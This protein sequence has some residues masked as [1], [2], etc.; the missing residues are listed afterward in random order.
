MLENGGSVV[1]ISETSA[2]KT[3]GVVGIWTAV[4]SIER[5]FGFFFK[6]SS[7]VIFGEDVIGDDFIDE[8][9]EKRSWFEGDFAGEF[10]FDFS[11]IFK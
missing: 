3:E 1:V 9:V 5:F 8:A 4:V 7:D 10:R 6:D 11:E 2:L